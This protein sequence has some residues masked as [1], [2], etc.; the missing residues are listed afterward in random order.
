MKNKIK[1]L[2]RWLKFGGQFW[3]FQIVLIL[4]S[5]LIVAFVFKYNNLAMII[6]SGGLILQILG[7]LTVIKDISARQKLFDYPYIL[8]EIRSW[9]QS[10]PFFV[11]HKTYTLFA[12]SG[13]YTITGSDNVNMYKS[14]PPDA[15]IE[16]RVSI[17]E[18][19]LNSIINNLHKIRK[20]FK[21]KM[22]ELNKK[23]DE[24]TLALRNDINTIGEKLTQAN[25]G[26]IKIQWNGVVW[27]LSGTIF[28]T[29]P[30]EI[31]DFLHKIF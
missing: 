9:W 23:M 18:Q 4:I 6:K 7:L 19:K 29:I 16:E 28:V 25:V 12:E 10:C 1:E 31:A 13:S 17:L 20:E 5:L 2:F 22:I 21:E 26:N 27:L 15:Q 24:Q 3:P 8:D 14:A 30:Q 11:K